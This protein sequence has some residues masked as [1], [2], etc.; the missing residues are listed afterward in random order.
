MKKQPA[1]KQLTLDTTKLRVLMSVLT[2]EQLNGV[3]GGTKPQSRACSA[4][5]VDC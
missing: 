3:A 2:S 5:T 4:A 1:T